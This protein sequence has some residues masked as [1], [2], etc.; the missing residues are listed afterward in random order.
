MTTQNEIIECWSEVIC[1]QIIADVRASTLFSI[2]ADEVTD[3]PTKEQMSLVLCYVDRKREIQEKF[4][5]FIHCD[6]GIS[7]KLSRIH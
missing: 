6:S 4:V 1:E 3:C 7:G 2:L 5:T